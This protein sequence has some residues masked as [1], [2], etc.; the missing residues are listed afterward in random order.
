MLTWKIAIYAETCRRYVSRTEYS[1]TVQ[2]GGGG[3]DDDDDDNNNNNNNRR[4]SRISY[5]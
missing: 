1:L 5:L 2:C 4:V 3:D